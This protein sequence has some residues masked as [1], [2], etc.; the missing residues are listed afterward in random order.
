MM[1]LIQSRR[2]DDLA[3]RL[4]RELAQA[5]SDPFTPEIVLVDQPGMEQWLAQRIAYRLGVCCAVRFVRPQTFVSDLLSDNPDRADP[6]SHEALRWTLRRIFEEPLGDELAAVR[7]YIDDPSDAPE[8]RRRKRSALAD[9]MAEVFGRYLRYR[10]ERLQAPPEGPND[11]QTTLWRRVQAAI[12]APTPLDQLRALN[13]RLHSGRVLIPHRVHVFGLSTLP[14]HTLRALA[15]LSQHCPVRWLRLL[16]SRPALEATGER[17]EKLPRLL[18]VLSTVDRDLESLLRAHVPQL[19]REYLD[20]D[21]P[22]STTTLSALQHDLA[23]ATRRGSVHGGERALPAL[24]DT[25][26]LH[27]CHGQTR[28]VEVLRNALLELFANE[29]ASLQ[30]RDVVVLCPNI[31]VWSPLIRAEFDDG[32]TDEPAPDAPTPS[33]G[34]PRLRHMV[35]DR[36]MRAENPVARALLTLMELAQG[37]VHASAVLDLLSQPVVRAAFGL[38]ADD[39]GEVQ[40]LFA[41]TGFRWG[42]DA[43]HRAQHERPDDTTHTLRFALDR[44]LLGMA[45]DSLDTRTFGGVL[46]LDD[47]EA[48]VARVAGPL[49]VFCDALCASLPEM[50]TE[51][52]ISEWV[53]TLEGLLDCFVRVA[54]DRQWQMA[55]VTETLAT[56]RTAAMAA[57]ATMPLSV[58]EVA[59]YLSGRCN[60]PLHAQG[61]VSGA[62]TFCELMPMRSIPFR[63]V[64]L[65]GLDE[66]AFPRRTARLNFDWLESTPRPGDRDPRA[67][68]HYLLLEAIMAARDHLIVTWAGY[69]SR[70]NAELPAPPMVQELADTVARMT[71]GGDRVVRHHPLHAFSPREFGWDDRSHRRMTPRGFDH[72]MRDAAEA[73]CRARTAEPAFLDGP[74]DAPEDLLAVVLLRDVRRCLEKGTLWY[75]ME[76]VLRVQEPRDLEPTNDTDPLEPD[77]LERWAVGDACLHHL[78]DHGLP[79]DESLR[80]LRLNGQLALGTSGDATFEIAHAE[81]SRVA[82]RVRELVGDANPEAVDVDFEIGGV[83]IQGRIGGLTGGRRVFSSFTRAGDGRLLAAWFEH[84]LLRCVR[85]EQTIDTHL[86]NRGD[87]EAPVEHVLLGDAATPEVARDHVESLVA[88]FVHAHRLPV[89]F[90]PAPSRAYAAALTEGASATDALAAARLSYEA[91]RPSLPDM[92]CYSRLMPEGPSAERSVGGV[93][94]PEGWS[95]GEIA[96]RVWSPLLAALDEGAD[97]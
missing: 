10:G 11:W 63:V 92:P 16:P 59:H 58:Q 19:R 76:R 90:V 14:P 21:P 60:V 24:D 93:S 25:L 5:P 57:G 75:L 82:E 70:S 29:Q 27:A 53:T 31:A 64:C 61:F 55:Q 86:I 73:L 36:R 87:A 9:R 78:E 67:E 30:P 37:R 8:V 41:E 74:L 40:R 77:P 3:D 72:R 88:L 85:P 28:Q 45:M 68:D 35:A 65:L 51:R 6:Y 66:D 62:I 13:E 91:S 47:V 38:S 89:P 52:P 42:L 94:L 34:F 48:G 56:A 95:F 97:S 23:H 46:P 84:L 69:S 54:P 26:Q 17:L 2:V 71:R 33:P 22:P 83:R 15:A 81:A 79:P 32:W 49:A 7:G 80:L 12:G 4:A 50:A 20:T 96:E 44:L 43:A 1:E 18:R 39:L